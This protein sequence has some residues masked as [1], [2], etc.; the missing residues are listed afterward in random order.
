MYVHPHSTERVGMAVTLYACIRVVLESDISQNIGYLDWHF[1]G[2]LQY[3]H[4]HAEKL[5][6][7]GLDRFLPHPFQFSTSLSFSHQMILCLSTDSM[8]KWLEQLS[9]VRYWKTWVCVENDRVFCLKICVFWG[10]RRTWY[11]HDIRNLVSH[12]I[13]YFSA[14]VISFRRASRI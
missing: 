11:I 8:M 4:S 9:A 13:I 3:L 1:H 5:P 14:V 7:L 6:R 2:F 10:S 12:W